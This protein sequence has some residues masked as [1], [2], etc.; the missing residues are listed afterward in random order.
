[1]TSPIVVVNDD[2]IRHK[3]PGPSNLKTN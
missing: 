1:M 2:D 3:T